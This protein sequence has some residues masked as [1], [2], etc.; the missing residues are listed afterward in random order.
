[1]LLSLFL[2]ATINLGRV[3]CTAQYVATVVFVISS[4]HSACYWVQAE[5]SWRV[6]VPFSRMR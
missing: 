3:A 4:A 5:G 2:Q 6:A 1:M